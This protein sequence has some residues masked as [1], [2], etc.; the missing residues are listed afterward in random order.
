MKLI[1]VF[2]ILIDISF[3][4][5]LQAPVPQILSNDE[6]NLI[7]QQFGDLNMQ[8]LCVI[9]QYTTQKINSIIDINSYIFKLMCPDI[10]QTQLIKKRQRVWTPNNKV[11]NQWILLFNQQKDLIKKNNLKNMIHSAQQYIDT[12]HLNIDNSF[13]NSNNIQSYNDYK[14]SIG[15]DSNQNLIYNT[16]C[17]HKDQSLSEIGNLQ[18]NLITDISK[19]TDINSIKQTLNQ[20]NDLGINANINPSSFVEIIYNQNQ[21]NLINN[22]Y[23]QSLF[24]NRNK[25]KNLCGRPQQALHDR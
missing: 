16:N 5:K 25:K 21:R 7:M 6:V 17:T 10:I 20:N 9:C 18:N 12:N 22:E 14:Q 2:W 4:L 23:I 1:N 13:I 3:C 8:E 11:I 15:I 19:N 24:K